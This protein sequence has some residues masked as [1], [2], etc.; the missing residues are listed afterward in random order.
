MSFNQM[1]K[2]C[3]A[4][5][6]FCSTLGFSQT[7]SVNVQSPSQLPLDPFNQIYKMCSNRIVQL[8]PFVMLEIDRLGASDLSP[9]EKVSEL[10]RS[11]TFLQNDFT[12]TSYCSTVAKVMNK[13]SIERKCR[14]LLTSDTVF[15]SETFSIRETGKTD[16]QISCVFSQVL[17][18][19]IAM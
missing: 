11:M 10:R 16:D 14:E 6:L 5:C 19:L 12:D 17:A 2:F 9:E 1:K 4:F 13:P 18:M 7:S 3:F 15:D 8:P